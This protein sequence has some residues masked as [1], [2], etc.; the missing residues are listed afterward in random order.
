MGHRDE[1]FTP[2]PRPGLFPLGGDVSS[3]A[4]RRLQL[5][6]VR[7]CPPLGRCLSATTA[8]AV[9]RAHSLAVG[10]QV[11]IVLGHER[12]GHLLADNLGHLVPVHAGV[13]DQEPVER[14]SS[15]QPLAPRLSMATWPGPSTFTTMLPLSCT[16]QWV[17]I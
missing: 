15:F 9:R 2:T 4:T 17:V 8:S 13:E 5:I 7:R 11:L 1:P 10:G 3:G 12:V 16:N 14:G 6:G